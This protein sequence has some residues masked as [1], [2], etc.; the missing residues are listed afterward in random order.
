MIDLEQLVETRW[1]NFTKAH[2]TGLGYQFTKSNDTFMVKIKDLPKASK[3]IVHAYCD[4]CGKQHNMQYNEYN[5]ALEKSGLYRCKEC[6]NKINLSSGYEDYT[7]QH[8]QRYLQFCEQNNYI[9]I[10]NLYDKIISTTKLP[11]ICPKHGITYIT[12]DGINRNSKCNMCGY[13]TMANQF[14]YSKEKVIEIV[15]SKNGNTLINPDDYINTSTKNLVINCGSC[16]TLF[17]TSLSAI[18]NGGGACIN[19]G[20]KKNSDLRKLSIEELNERFNSEDK[21]KLLNPNDYIN[22]YTKNLRFIC[23]ECGDEYITSLSNYQSGDIRCD[24]CK[25]IKSLGEFLIAQFLD[26]YKISYIPQKRYK[27]CIDIRP[28]PFDFYLEEY[29]CIIEFDGIQ[30]YEPVYGE[31]RLEYVKRHDAIKTKYCDDNNIRLIRIPYWE[32]SKIR[33]I[34]MKEFNLV[35][36]KKIQYPLK[37]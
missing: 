24:K 16:N 35:P 29:N 4:E 8:V 18:I 7:E 14:K 37:K 5:D 33:D 22:N 10:D 23:S 2:Y 34:L 13:D 17:E 12:P 31:E 21:I 1:N 6:T 19:C 3:V 26:E 32:T 11:Y 9:P 25:P 30:H 27:D 20:V 15:E 36:I 28:L